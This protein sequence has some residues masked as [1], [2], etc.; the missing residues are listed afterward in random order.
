MNLISRGHPFVWT[1]RGYLCWRK[2]FKKTHLS[3]CTQD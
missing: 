1:F 3:V 2:S